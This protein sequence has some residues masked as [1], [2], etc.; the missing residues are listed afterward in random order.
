MNMSNIENL[1]IRI[2]AD[3]ADLK[4]MIEMSKKPYIFGLTTNPSLMKK[5]GVTDYTLFAKQLLSRI[6]D[7]PISFEVIS[8]DISE[9]FLQAM[10]INSWASNVFVKIPVC[11]T[12]G[13]STASLIKSLQSEGVKI[14]VTAVMTQSQLDEVASVLLPEVPTVISIF[15]GRIADTGVMPE[16]LFLEANGYRTQLPS[17]KLLWASTRQTLDIFRAEAVD[18]DYITVPN[19]ILSKLPL[20]GRDLGAYSAETVKMFYDDA[21][22]SGLIL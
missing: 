21:I 13:T 1:R 8:N 9:M 11:L 7:K 14:N 4:S 16:E 5:A 18:A 10:K 12:D 17:L 19:E 3:G 2:F 6:N 15:S 20:L 22:S